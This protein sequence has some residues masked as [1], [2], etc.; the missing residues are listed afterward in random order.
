MVAEVRKAHPEASLAQMSTLMQ[1]LVVI[2]LSEHGVRLL[3][4]DTEQPV[5]VLPE[6]VGVMADDLFR[7]L[8]RL[9]DIGDGIWLGI[10]IQAEH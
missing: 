1:Q 8:N 6:G 3:D 4:V 10:P 9:P 7:T 5:P 2:L